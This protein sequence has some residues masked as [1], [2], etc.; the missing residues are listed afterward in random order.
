MPRIRFRDVRRGCPRGLEPRWGA[1]AA[2]S[3]ETPTVAQRLRRWNVACEGPFVPLQNAAF[4]VQ[5][6][7]AQRA[8]RRNAGV[9]MRAPPLPRAASALP[10]GPDLH[11]DLR[12]DLHVDSHADLRGNRLYTLL[13]GRTGRAFTLS[14]YSRRVRHPSRN[15]SANTLPMQEQS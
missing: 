8:R 11:G 13:P 15:S 6:A 10:S 7:C 12:S 2:E 5:R 4:A 1:I 14:L 3:T 9:Q